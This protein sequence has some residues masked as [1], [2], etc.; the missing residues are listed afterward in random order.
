MTGLKKAGLDIILAKL[1]REN[2]IAIRHGA[3]MLKKPSRVSDL[4]TS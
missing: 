3:V 4:T 2:R 1:E